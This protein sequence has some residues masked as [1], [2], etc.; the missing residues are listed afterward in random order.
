MKKILSLFSV[1]ALSLTLCSCTVAKKSNNDEQTTS[2]ISQSITKNTT[3]IVKT[4]KN[5]VKNVI[6]YLD[7]ISKEISITNRIIKDAASIMAEE[8]F[9]FSYGGNKYELYKFSGKGELKKAETGTYT[10]VVIGAESLGEITTKTVVNGDYVMF[11][12]EADEDVISVFN[13]INAK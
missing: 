10:F 6:E 1:L 12:D 7:A 2:N 13:S 11:Y 5:K 9:G 4:E 8:G 3:E